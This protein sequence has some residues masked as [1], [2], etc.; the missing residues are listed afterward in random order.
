MRVMGWVNWWAPHWLQRAVA[1]LGLYEGPM[2]PGRTDAP[3]AIGSEP[4]SA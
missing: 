2:E 3:A 1:R 4:A